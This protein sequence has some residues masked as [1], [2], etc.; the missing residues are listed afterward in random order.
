MDTRKHTHHTQ[1]MEIKAAV[2]LFSVLVRTAMGELGE[3]LLVEEPAGM[4]YLPQDDDVEV[5][6]ITLF[7][8]A[9]KVTCALLSS[10]TSA[11]LIPAA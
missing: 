3:K 1:T 5:E 4:S 11:G 2:P 10:C 7:N 6:L 9:G 8:D